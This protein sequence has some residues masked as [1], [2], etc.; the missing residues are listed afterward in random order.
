[1]IATC[2]QLAY[3]AAS[4]VGPH[5]CCASKCRGPERTHMD[6]ELIVAVGNLSRQAIV[7]QAGCVMCMVKGVD[8]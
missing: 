1:M 5:L 4:R 2:C 3:K 7:P 8:W 6:Q